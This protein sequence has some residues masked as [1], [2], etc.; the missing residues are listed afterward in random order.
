MMMELDYCELLKS[1]LA[2]MGK[3][4]RPFTVPTLNF[5]KRKLLKQCII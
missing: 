1:Y 2:Q 4:R 3:G 5:D